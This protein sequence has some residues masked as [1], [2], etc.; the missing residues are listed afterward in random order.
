M[1]APAT[2]SIAICTWNRCELLGQTLENLANVVAACGRPVDVVVVNNKCTDATSQVIA[3]FHDR[4]RIVELHEPTP[5]LSHARNR[6]LSALKSDF[7]AWIDDDV[8]VDADWLNVLLEGIAK[9]PDAAAFGGLI[10]PWF[11]FPPDPDFLASFPFLANGFCGLNHGDE[12][13]EL[14]PGEWLYGANMVYSSRFTGGLRFDPNLGTV[15]GSGAGGEETMYQQAI[16]DRGGRT[17]WLPGMKVKHFVEPSRMTLSYLTR[18][19]YDRGRTYMRL[20]PRIEEPRF[21]GA[22]RW[23]WRIMIESYLRYWGL[24]FMSSRQRALSHLREYH[25]TR[26]MVAEA[27]ARGVK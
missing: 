14:A 19:A 1:T 16:L 13:R 23:A 11:A 18:Y 26:G 3:G 6:A 2:I 24:R 20:R 12:E 8:R 9:Y 27:R 10:E 25:S 17:V 4:L 5:G 15:Q 7:V 22:P 21:L